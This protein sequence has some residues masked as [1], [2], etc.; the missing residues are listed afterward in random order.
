MIPCINFHCHHLQRKREQQADAQ[1][2]ERHDG[3]I[4]N[5]HIKYGLGQTTLIPR[6]TK[7]V[8]TNWKYH[9]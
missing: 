9:K 7:T 6:I 3:A 1:R 8:I 5:T 2:N 4:E